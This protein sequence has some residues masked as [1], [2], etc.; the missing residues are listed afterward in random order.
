M[1][2]P[3]IVVPS[4][5]RKGPFQKGD[6]I[7]DHPTDLLNPEATISKT[8]MSFVK[9]KGDFDVLVIGAPTRSSIGKEMDKAILEL[10]ESLKLPYKVYYYGFEEFKKL[11]K[12]LTS[13][14]SSNISDLFSNREYG[15]I[16]NQC[17]LIPHLLHYDVAILIDD[18]EIITDHNFINKATEFI[19][20]KSDGNTLGLILG[21]YRNKDSSILLDET[22]VPWWELVW[23]KTEMMN[24]AFQIIESSNLK[25]LVDTPFA[26]G[27]NMVIHRNCW[28]KVPFDP[29]ITRGE[30]MDYLR[31]VKQLG[32]DAKLDKS[33]SIIH[34]PPKTQISYLDKFKQDIFRFLYAR[35]KCESLGIKTED[36]DPYP[37][38]FLKQTEGK[39]LIT[40]LLYHIFHNY[41]NIITVRSSEEFFNKLQERQS[42]FDNASKFAKKN[43]KFYIKFQKK[44]EEFMNNLQS[45]MPVEIVKN[46]Q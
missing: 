13:Q 45:E 29:L 22:K 24:K 6:C 11:K 43:S 25:R 32:F 7:Y 23:N 44:W 18:D 12:Y 1:K 20:K 16:R 3:I 38:F 39:V 40:E 30:D 9:I 34:N 10:I 33:L 5:W 31:N 2:K 42:I 21:F 35:A 17:I 15:N 19:G 8:L 27:G 37:G 26:L 14:F 41:E 46:I 4:Y 28:S 36:Y